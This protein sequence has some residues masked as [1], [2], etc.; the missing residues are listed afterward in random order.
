M[1]LVQLSIISYPTQPLFPALG[2]RA[3]SSD[4][5]AQ[6]RP[7]CPDNGGPTWNAHSAAHLPKSSHPHISAEV[8]LLISTSSHPKVISLIF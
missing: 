4:P 1:D 3:P 6:R 8:P 2:Q 7:L 5:L